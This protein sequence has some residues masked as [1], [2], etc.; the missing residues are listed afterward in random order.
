MKNLIELSSEE[1]LNIDGGWNLLEYIAYG[2]GACCAAVANG[3]DAQT[4]GISNGY[5]GVRR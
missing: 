2:V 1:M 5:V 3:I 4:Q